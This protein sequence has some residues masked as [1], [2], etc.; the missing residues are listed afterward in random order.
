MKK[1]QSEDYNLYHNKIEEISNFLKNQRI[2]ITGGTGLFGYWILDFFLNINSYFNLES[3]VTLLTRRNPSEILKNIPLEF[4]KYIS[5][6]QGDIR[7]FEFPEQEF[8]FLIHGSGLPKSSIYEIEPFA[9]NDVIVNGTTHILKLI[10]KSKIKKLLFISSGA[11]YGD[12][13][14]N[15]DYLS[16]DLNIA[17]STIQSSSLYG[18]AK[19]ISEILCIIAGK[20]N[21]VEVKIARCFTFTGSNIPLDQHFAVGNFIN[22]VLNNR[23]ILITG[24]SRTIR[25]YMYSTD[26]SHWLWTILLEGKNNEIYNV[27]SD[28]PIS[29][30]ELAN[31]VKKVTNHKGKI[32]ENKNFHNKT[33]NKYLPSIEKAKSDLSLK[34]NVNIEEAIEKTYLWW[35]N[36]K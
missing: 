3:N 23:D 4:H 18:E 6:I 14:F 5:F 30:L 25:S 2:L 26:L 24:D 32:I 12:Q 20:E 36:Y 16:E 27:G 13:P 21:Q 11:A 19:R 15:T 1:N 7:N 31:L 10:K 8:D 35:K 34:I 29:I 17:P 28:E 33:F 22:D 9:M